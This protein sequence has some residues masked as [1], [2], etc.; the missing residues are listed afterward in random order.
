MLGPLPTWMTTANKWYNASAPSSPTVVRR[1]SIENGTWYDSFL[2]RSR[3]STYLKRFRWMAST[4]G[5]FLIRMHFCASCREQHTSQKN[6]S[7]WCNNSEA[8][9]LR[10]QLWSET[11]CST[12]TLKSMNAS[13]RLV[14]VSHV[15]HRVSE[16]STPSNRS[17]TKDFFVSDAE[18]LLQEESGTEVRRSMSG[19]PG[20][21]SHIWDG[22]APFPGDR[23]AHPVPAV[24]RAS[25]DA[26]PSS[27]P[28]LA[29]HF[30]LSRV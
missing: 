13:S 24:G 10:R 11:F 21:V 29:A 19:A 20:R 23:A 5:A 18:A 30:L 8:E 15:R 6:L 1:N 27:L 26:S 2:Y 12:S 14:T 22:W 3:C 16:A 17:C 25:W 28:K 4:R 7:S 9:K